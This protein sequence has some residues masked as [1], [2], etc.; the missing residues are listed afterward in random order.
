MKLG[1]AKDLVDGLADERD[2][3]TDTVETLDHQ[4]DLLPG[5]VLIAIA[6]VAYLGP[7]VTVYREEMTEIWKKSVR[8]D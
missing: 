8:F 5:D 1:R 4:F 6:S 3:W 7:F 2:R